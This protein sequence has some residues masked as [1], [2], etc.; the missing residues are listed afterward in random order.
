MTAVKGYTEQTPAK[1]AMVNANKIVEEG[2]LRVLDQLRGV[3]GIDLAWLTIGQR[4]IEQG[5]MAVNRSIMQPQRIALPED[6]EGDE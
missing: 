5:F 1:L 2:V 3:E 6:A 4:H